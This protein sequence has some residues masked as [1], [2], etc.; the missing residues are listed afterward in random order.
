ML[1]LRD[2]NLFPY[3]YSEQ[4]GQKNK[5]IEPQLIQKMAELKLIFV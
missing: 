4:N 1:N 3:F 2:F 5:V